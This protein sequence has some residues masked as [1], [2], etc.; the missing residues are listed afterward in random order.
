MSRTVS[1]WYSLKAWGGSIWGFQICNFHMQKMKRSWVP[2]LASCTEEWAWRKYITNREQPSASDPK[3]RTLAVFFYWT[4][5]LDWFCLLTSSLSLQWGFAVCATHSSACQDQ[6]GFSIW[7]PTCRK[8][9]WQP[10]VQATQDLGL[11]AGPA[12]KWCKQ[13]T[14]GSW[15][16]LLDSGIE[17]WYSPGCQIY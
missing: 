10:R 2:S 3:Y 11:E 14:P 7:D 4:V 15:E 17:D 9:C 8:R 1:Q 13:W 12:S 16:R 6:S 5:D